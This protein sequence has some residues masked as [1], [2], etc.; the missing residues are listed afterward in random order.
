[1][2]LLSYNY[3]MTQWDRISTLTLTSYVTWASYLTFLNLYFLGQNSITY[4]RKL[5]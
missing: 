2:Q 1:M 4:F 5:M 3:V